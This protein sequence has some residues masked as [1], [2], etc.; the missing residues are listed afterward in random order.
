[1]QG[2]R[3]DRR[4]GPGP[5]R[6]QLPPVGA[7][8][9]GAGWRG[10]RPKPARP[11][12]GYRKAVLRRR[13]SR[14]ASTRRC[15]ADVD[16]DA[17]TATAGAADA[18]KMASDNGVATEGGTGAAVPVS[19]PLAARGPISEGVVTAPDV[20]A[21]GCAWS[22]VEVLSV[23]EA[24]T[25]GVARTVMGP[26]PQR[27]ARRPRRRSSSTVSTL[28]KIRSAP[29]FAQRPESA[30]RPGSAQRSEPA[31]KSEP[32]QRSGRLEVQG[33]APAPLA[34]RTMWE[35][36]RPAKALTRLPAARRPPGSVGS[37]P[38]S[39]SPLWSRLR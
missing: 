27:Q 22:A 5:Q 38:R 18:C 4:L 9:S 8:P 39:S 29:E 2:R 28:W 26:K 24:P 1:M 25:A 35:P 37:R 21:E 32:A 17:D 23:S 31:Q 6:S 34:R 11:R 10:P 20:V 33:L 14:P 12:T 19:P 36:Q 15:D 7:E 16:A 30:Q 13:R 3:E